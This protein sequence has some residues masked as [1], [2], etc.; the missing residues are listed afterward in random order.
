MIRK[1]DE[2]V[3]A[4]RLGISK[5]IF[6]YQN[7]FEGEKDN[8]DLLRKIE[9]YL[10]YDYLNLIQWRKDENLSDVKDH[11]M[12]SIETLNLIL[13]RFFIEYPSDDDDCEEQTNGK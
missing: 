8:N 3:R 12:G 7:A 11:M 2:I 5:I 13:F 6:A 4:V 1:D 9:L 10:I